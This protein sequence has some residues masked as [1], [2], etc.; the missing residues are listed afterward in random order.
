[1]RA[2]KLSSSAIERVAYDEE[3][4]TLSIWFRQSGRY[5]YFDVPKAIYDQLCAA[6]SAGRYFAECVKGRFR[7]AFDPERRRFR[8]VH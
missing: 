7:C 1:M 2:T 6:S 4:R 5:L 3:E 8:P